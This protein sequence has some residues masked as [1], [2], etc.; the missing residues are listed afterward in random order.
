[1]GTSAPHLKKD[2]F[3]QLVIILTDFLIVYETFFQRV[4]LFL[5]LNEFEIFGS[6]RHYK[7]KEITQDEWSYL[8][9]YA[10]KHDMDG[11]CNEAI[12]FK[13]NSHS[14]VALDKDGTIVKFTITPIL[15]IDKIILLWHLPN[16]EERKLIKDGIVFTALQTMQWIDNLLNDFKK[17]NLAI[18]NNILKLKRRSIISSTIHKMRRGFSIKH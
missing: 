6:T 16:M 17:K 4:K 5:E 8:I 12:C 10:Y 1:M 7:L 13:V 14:L 9:A 2:A 3:D 15:Q 18:T 11:I